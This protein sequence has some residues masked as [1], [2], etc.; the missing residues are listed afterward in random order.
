MNRI[1]LH[2]AHGLFRPV[3]TFASL[4]ILASLGCGGGETEE[5]PR[6]LDPLKDDPAGALIL[7]AVQAHG[8]WTAWVENETVEYDVQWTPFQADGSP[9]MTGREHHSFYLLG[10]RIRG[11]VDRPEEDL[12]MAYN[13][14]VAW[15]ARD[16]GMRADPQMEAPAL[17][18]VQRIVWI[19]RIPFN[20]VDRNVRLVDEGTEGSFR[21]IKVQFPAGMGV[22]EEDWARIYLDENTHEVRQLFLNA[23]KGR[24]WM[25]FLD[26]SE[27]DGILLPHKRR[28]YKV[29]PDGSRGAVSHE[30]E[31]RNI[32]F[33]STLEDSLF[34]PPESYSPP[35]PPGAP[36]PD[37]KSGEGQ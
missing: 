7:E 8:G 33:N 16:G 32:L 9:G 3:R 18:Y 30:I 1:R 5:L 34:D 29:N 26:L 21:K 27:V 12:L 19:F 36:A 11:R 28:V 37:I 17:A 31:L 4:A 35:T 23:A 15:A 25:E 2:L 24:T 6:A 14:F 20:L 22:L 10:N 13:G